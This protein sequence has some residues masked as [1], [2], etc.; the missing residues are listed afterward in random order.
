VCLQYVSVLLLSKVYSLTK[1][2]LTLVE[3]RN[4]VVKKRE[5]K[6]SKYEY[7]TIQLLLRSSLLLMQVASKR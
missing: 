7:C 1:M 3:Q 2:T 6:L 5:E 4:Y